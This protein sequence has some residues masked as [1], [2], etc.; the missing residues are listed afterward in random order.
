MNGTRRTPAI[1]AGLA[2]SGVW[3]IPVAAHAAPVN[4][5][6]DD[7][8][9]TPLVY[10]ALGCV[11]GAAVAGTI[12]GIAAHH[13]VKRLRNEVR[14]LEARSQ[15]TPAVEE[16]NTEA[17]AEE[18]APA[19][20]AP[21]QATPAEVVAEELAETE[22]ELDTTASLKRVEE[23]KAEEEDTTASLGRVRVAQ[24][25]P[26]APAAAPA[27]PAA[28]P[29]ASV[30][31]PVVQANAPT[32]RVSARL[33]AALPTIESAPA[34]ADR[35]AAARQEAVAAAHEYAKA[36]FETRKRR[37]ARGVRA[38]L[39]ERL[40]DGMLDGLPVIERADGS[41]ADVGTAWWDNTMNGRLIG[42]A[43]NTANLA[44]ATESVD[45]LATAAL[46]RAELQRAARNAQ[47]LGTADLS[48]PQ[49]AAGAGALSSTARLDRASRSR[50][51][52]SRIAGF[53]E[54]LYPDRGVESA[55][56]DTFEEAM[57]AMDAQIPAV[58][59]RTSADAAAAVSMLDT[60][61]NLKTGAVVTADA[62]ADAD[63]S[64]AAYVD[65]LVQEE[66]ERNRAGRARRYS[67]SFLTV[68]EGTG[69]LSDA[70]KAAN[71]KHFPREPREKEA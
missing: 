52:Q 40:G 5:T 59:V 64:A 12:A 56:V 20:P 2:G 1:F 61:A 45:P 10:F 54:S 16:P 57:R 31:A 69:D 7:L 3:S 11:A 63:S 19:G 49:L 34:P 51:I 62:N 14:E 29:A 70:R 30:E 21:A 65:R 42:M 44:P 26:V 32:R 50:A 35:A 4:V 25:E 46:R 67:R 23:P 37:R 8:L 60:T 58:G 38:I 27:A 17:P 22:S 39:S 71:A 68:F 41:V 66:V 43:D 48:R 6:I 47:I 28:A 9:G 13:S 55:D 33:D 36:D 53:D 15:A 24:E 18:V